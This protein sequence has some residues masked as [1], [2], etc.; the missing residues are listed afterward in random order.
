[1]RPFHLAFPVTELD[2][3]KSFYD[4]VLQVPQLL[5]LPARGVRTGKNP[6]HREP[7]R[8]R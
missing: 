4:D 7:S 5:Y 8:R 2:T 3:T 6:L 1:M